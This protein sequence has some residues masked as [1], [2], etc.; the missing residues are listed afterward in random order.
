LWIVDFAREH[1]CITIGD[2]IELTG[3]SRN[4]LKQHSRTRVERRHLNQQ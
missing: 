2:T 3:L 4:T 1:G